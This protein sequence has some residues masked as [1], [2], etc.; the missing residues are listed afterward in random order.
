MKLQKYEAGT[1]FGDKS[2]RTQ[3]MKHYAITNR[4]AKKEN[5]QRVPGN[6]DR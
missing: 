2:F 6:H 5:N 3:K 4:M 1:R